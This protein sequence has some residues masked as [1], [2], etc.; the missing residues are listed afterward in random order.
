MS[1]TRLI[2]SFKIFNSKYNIYYL[3]FMHNKSTHATLL[4]KYTR[5][6][7]K[8]KTFVESLNNK[9]HIQF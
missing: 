4:M 5:T 8:F 9:N 6:H 2:K 3:I 1:K 7:K